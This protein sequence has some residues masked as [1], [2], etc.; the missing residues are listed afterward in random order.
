LLSI[1]VMTKK[2]D[3]DQQDEATEFERKHEEQVAFRGLL[4]DV[5]ANAESNA[6]NPELC[7]GQE[8]VVDREGRLLVDLP[9]PTSRSAPKK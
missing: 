9:R 2:K 7:G 4:G 3:A 5:C 6:A 8:P 1:N